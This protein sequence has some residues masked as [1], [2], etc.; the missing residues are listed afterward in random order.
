MRIG[1]GSGDTCAG[2]LFVDVSGK[3]I[4]IGLGDCNS[5]ANAAFLNGSVFVRAASGA[6]CG[7]SIDLRIGINAGERGSNGGGVVDRLTGTLDLR[8][9]SKAAF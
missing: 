5:R 8:Y 3:V 9:D 6:C 2:S 1:L 4:R 7:D